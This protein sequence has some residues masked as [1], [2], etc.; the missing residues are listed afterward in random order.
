VALVTHIYGAVPSKIFDLLPA[1]VPILFCGNG[2]GADIVSS[3]GFGLVCSNSN[4]KGLEDNIRTMKNM[5]EQDYGQ[6]SS[7]CKSAS[8]GKFS[9]KR[10][11]QDFIDFLLE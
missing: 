8:L 2:E 7:N 10:Q 5:S 9:F 1:G 6:L 11:M 3:N 4:Y